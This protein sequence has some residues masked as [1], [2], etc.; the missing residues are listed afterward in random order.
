MLLAVDA[1]YKSKVLYINLNMH[2]KQFCQN[3][4]TKV[5]ECRLYLGGLVHHCHRG[6]RVLGQVLVQVRLLALQQR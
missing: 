3:V 2:R 4:R 1:V 5:P 6:P